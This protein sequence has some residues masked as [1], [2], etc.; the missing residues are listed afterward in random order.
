MAREV[1]ISVTPGNVLSFDADVLVL[2]Y[3]SGL[4][5]AD[6]EVAERLETAGISMSFPEIHQWESSATSGAI[7]AKDVIFIGVGPLYGFEYPQI[8]EFARTAIAAIADRF[9]D[10]RHAAVTL[11]GPGYGLDEMEAFDSEVAGLIDGLRARAVDTRLLRITIVEFDRRR[12]R[13]LAARLKELLADSR[14]NLDEPS[15]EAQLPRR[16]RETVRNA[17]YTTVTKT[18]VLAV[19]PFS[20]GT[21]DDVY[22][23]GIYKPANELGL[24]CERADHAIFTD[25]VVQ[26]VKEKI[27]AA[28][29]VVADITGA[30]PNVYLEVGYCWGLRKRPVL[31]IRHP[32]EPKFNL[33]TQRCFIYKSIGNLEEQLKQ[34]YEAF[35][36]I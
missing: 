28:D 20:E 33:K 21:M 12:A 15:A 5:G 17:G 14:I 19:M 7:A 1:T 26:W 8:R 35:R 13:R 24:L 34:V 25:D 29:I 32:E 2:K 18:R 10:A 36:A 9:A 31:V 3:A 4:Y 27:A 23:Y 11:H 30:N 22:K 16:S 6:A